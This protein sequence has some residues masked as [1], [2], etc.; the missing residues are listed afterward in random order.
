M[1]VG[2]N[3][4]FLCA[5]D[6]CHTNRLLNLLI[7]GFDLPNLRRLQNTA[8]DFDRAYC[9]VPICEPTIG[10]DLSNRLLIVAVRR[11]VWVMSQRPLR[12]K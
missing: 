9:V 11:T 3:I 7:A 1:A 8:T 6:L 4:L 2:D 12:S 10:G 5:D